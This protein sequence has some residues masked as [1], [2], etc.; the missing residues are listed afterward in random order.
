MVAVLVRGLVKLED[1][2]PDLPT[3]FVITAKMNWRFV[4]RKYLAA[5]VIL[6]IRIENAVFVE[7]IQRIHG[8]KEARD[9]VAAAVAREVPC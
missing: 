5:G 1:G 2:G 6:A 9:V 7:H 3:K 8:G 4:G